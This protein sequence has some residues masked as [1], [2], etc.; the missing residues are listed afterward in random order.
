M[1]S[2]SGL[3]AYHPASKRGEKT[4]EINNIE[5]CYGVESTKP[6]TFTRGIPSFECALT[7]MHL[8]KL[9]SAC[10]M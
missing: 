6:G 10:A 5:Q 3:I 7:S 4:N 2:V 8:L 1:K 9:F